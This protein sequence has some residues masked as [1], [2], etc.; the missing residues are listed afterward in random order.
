MIIF[1]I[2]R[3]SEIQSATK[4]LVTSIPFNWSLRYLKWWETEL[5]TQVK[6]GCQGTREHSKED[7][8]IHWDAE[9]QFR[10]EIS[11]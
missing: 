1:I 3:V 5:T 10:K 9:F 7:T 6:P 8:S 11:N 4:L 2:R